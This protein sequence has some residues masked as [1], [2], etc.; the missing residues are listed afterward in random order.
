MKLDTLAVAPVPQRQLVLLDFGSAAFYDEDLAQR[1]VGTA[2]LTI[3]KSKYQPGCYATASDAVLKLMVAN[4]TDQ[5]QYTPADEACSLIYC[6]ALTMCTRNA[7]RGFNNPKD[8]LN[9]RW[10]FWNAL[11]FHGDKHRDVVMEQLHYLEEQRLMQ[12]DSGTLSRRTTAV[13]KALNSLCELSLLI[14]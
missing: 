1:T 10:G 11:M 4:Y 6:V 7:P 12:C 13:I 8:A 3:I 9:W 5:V 2:I 14:E